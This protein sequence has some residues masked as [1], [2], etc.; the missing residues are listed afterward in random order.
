MSLG[1]AGLFLVLGFLKEVGKEVDM[2][3]MRGSK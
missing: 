1:V 2:R 3:M